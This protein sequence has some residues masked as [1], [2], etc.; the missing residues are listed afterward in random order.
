M[1]NTATHTTVIKRFGMR[2][3]K[4]F[5]KEASSVT[6]VEDILGVPSSKGR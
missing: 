2:A 1:E 4:N 3:P 6:R 5:A